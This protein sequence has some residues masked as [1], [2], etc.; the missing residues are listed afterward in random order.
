MHCCTIT[1]I[2]TITTPGLRT[3]VFVSIRPTVDPY[4]MYDLKRHHDPYHTPPFYHEATV[5]FG[6]Y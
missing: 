2:F 3:G 6:L 4:D 1:K 5:L